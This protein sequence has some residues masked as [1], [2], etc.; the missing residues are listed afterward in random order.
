M[1]S[2]KSLPALTLEYVAES[3]VTTSV[4]ALNHWDWTEA[5]WLYGKQSRLPVI[6]GGLWTLAHGVTN[7][8]GN[9]CIGLGLL[10]VHGPEETPMRQLQARMLQ[11][12]NE[13]FVPPMTRIPRATKR[14][15]QKASIFR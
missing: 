15:K 12:W 1:T 5:L 11:L 4:P 10:D 3:L 14:G 2:E 6:G 8:R 9:V 7:L 13:R